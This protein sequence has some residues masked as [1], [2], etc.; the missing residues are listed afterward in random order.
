MTEDIDVRRLR[1][2]PQDVLVVTKTTAAEPGE[3]QRA[4][5]G[6]KEHL[7]AHGLASVKIL[8][9]DGGSVTVLSADPWSA[10]C[11]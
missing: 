11:A 10:A 7:V 3:M 6:L 4:I 2:Q 5:E 8:A 9:I 1:L